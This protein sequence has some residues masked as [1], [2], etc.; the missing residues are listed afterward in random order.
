MDVIQ[1]TLFVKQSIC[2]SKL[3]RDFSVFGGA[4]VSRWATLACLSLGILYSTSL[5][6]I[7]M[8]RGGAQC[9]SKGRTDSNREQE[10]VQTLFL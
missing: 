9:V 5:G 2:S 8:L 10:L 7:S 1:N 6:I 4:H 3:A